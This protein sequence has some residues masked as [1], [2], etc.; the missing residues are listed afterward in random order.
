MIGLGNNEVLKTSTKTLTFVDAKANTDA[1]GSTI[2]LCE[3]CSEDG[4]KQT[5][6]LEYLFMSPSTCSTAN[7][8]MHF[9]E[10]P[11][12]IHLV[13]TVNQVHKVM[14]MVLLNITFEPVHD[15]TNKM[16]YASS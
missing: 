13:G 1:K 7:S 15:K 8:K 6:L 10:K 2:A 4:K 5:H 3:C 12:I 16:A 14:T 9:H 11:I